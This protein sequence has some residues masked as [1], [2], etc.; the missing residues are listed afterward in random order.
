MTIEQIRDQRTE[1]QL[2]VFGDWK[3]LTNRVVF[4][5]NA[6][7]SDIRQH[8][9]ITQGKWVRASE[10][11]GIEIPAYGIAGLDITAAGDSFDRHA[12]HQLRPN[13]TDAGDTRS[14]SD[15]DRKARGVSLHS[16]HLPL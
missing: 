11:V 8:A 13:C 10:C 16:R 2:R 9:R 3:G 14:T 4:S 12:R 6:T 5:Q 1:N 15:L 7:L